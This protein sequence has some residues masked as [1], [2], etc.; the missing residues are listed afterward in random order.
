MEV[1][2]PF[3]VFYR[4]IRSVAENMSERGRKKYGRRWDGMVICLSFYSAVGTLSL[5]FFGTVARRGREGNLVPQGRTL[6]L[7]LPPFPIPVLRKSVEGGKKEVGEL[8]G[9]GKSLL[10]LLLPALVLTGAP[11]VL[12]L[13][14]PGGE[15]EHNMEAEM[16]V[17]PPPPSGDLVRRQVRTSRQ[18]CPSPPVR[19]NIGERREE[20][21]KD[22]SRYYE[23]HG[24]NSAK[25]ASSYTPN[26]SS[27]LRCVSR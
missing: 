12:L 11:T 2:Y 16:C 18:S 17:M 9:L 26:P 14:I 8:N 19:S 24:G 4:L 13:V 22:V 21:H 5:P 6:P 20:A 15:R 3:A 7:F 27:T 25:H 10:L 1:I 23:D